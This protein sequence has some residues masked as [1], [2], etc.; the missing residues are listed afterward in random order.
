[1]QQGSPIR[2]L[3]SLVA[4][5]YCESCGYWDRHGEACRYSSIL[6]VNIQDAFST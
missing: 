2:L 1:M 3:F 5:V 6:H 4:Y